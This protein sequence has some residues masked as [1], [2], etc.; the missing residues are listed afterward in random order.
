MGKASRNRPGLIA[1]VDRETKKKSRPGRMSA[2]LKIR[3]EARFVIGPGIFSCPNIDSLI[4]KT[5]PYVSILE[6]RFERWTKKNE[7]VML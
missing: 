4:A 5:N 2:G 6:N 3:N 1:D 7:K